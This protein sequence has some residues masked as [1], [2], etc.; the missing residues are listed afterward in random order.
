G[1]GLQRGW[2]PQGGPC[3]DGEV[4]GAAVQ[5]T[6]SLVKM[7]SGEWV[8]VHSVIGGGR[9]RPRIRVA[10]SPE[11]EPEEGGLTGAPWSKHALD[12]TPNWECI[13]LGAVGG[14]FRAGARMAKVHGVVS[15]GAGVRKLVVAVGEGARQVAIQS[16]LKDFSPARVEGWEAN[17][18]GSGERRRRR[19][20]GPVGEEGKAGKKKQQRRA[21]KRAVA[22]ADSDETEL[23]SDDES[24]ELRG[25][26]AG[27][28]KAKRRRVELESEEWEEGSS[29]GETA[30]KRVSRRGSCGEDDRGGGDGRRSPTGR[31]GSR[32][33]EHA[34]EGEEMDRLIPK[35]VRL[36]E[37]LR[38][39]F[40]KQRLREA[41]HYEWPVDLDDEEE[42]WAMKL[43]A[44]YA[45][46]RLQKV[47][48]GEVWPR[49]KVRSMAELRELREAVDDALVHK[50]CGGRVAEPRG[51]RLAEV[52][53]LDKEGAG[54]SSSGSGAKPL[55][56]EY[57]QGAFSSDVAARIHARAALV[58]FQPGEDVGGGLRAAPASLRDDL[59]RA[60]GSNGRIDAA[61]EVGR[62]R[63]IMPLVVKHMRAALLDEVQIALMA[64]PSED[65]S[66]T[67]YM[68]PSIA[69]KLAS[70]SVAGQFDV[71][72]EYGKEARFV[73]GPS[74][75]AADTREGL[76]E[77]WRVLR[78]ALAAVAEPLYGVKSSDG[79]IA[80]VEA[81]VSAT[82]GSLKMDVRAVYHHMLRRVFEQWG[83]ECRRFRQSDGDR[84][85]FQW[86]VETHSNFFHTKA[87]VAAFRQ[88]L[89]L[90]GDENDPGRRQEGRAGSRSLLGKRKE[91]EQRRGGADPPREG[92]G[93][94][95]EKKGE[96]GRSGGP[97]PTQSAWPSKPRMDEEKFE[98]FCEAVRKSCGEF[99]R[100]FLVGRCKKTDCNRPHKVTEAFKQLQKDFA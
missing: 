35:G 3:L 40:R 95:S 77:A 18:R 43:E 88:E 34:G 59:A 19:E 12:E 38:V 39:F 79:G 49:Q 98:K 55:A 5:Q 76:R 23:S 96:G 62:E 31:V 16:F 15:N 86:C 32:G 27:G 71:V 1:D 90:K 14:E 7:G 9:G 22:G 48:G 25:E 73:L 92:E 80:K 93:R 4:E 30:T 100:F 78:V 69:L 54:P 26:A 89:R 24:G 44:S 75:P 83:L 61:G 99:C 81:R 66:G 87:A 64:V 70:A 2:H 11:A 56:A 41:A 20:G 21:A 52:V 6:Q 94:G 28:G 17:H 46:R 57:V 91:D 60:I 53:D 33:E 58:S 72:E 13:I 10:T 47:V 37:A 97:P 74:A 8:V 63:T 82:A 51:G 42:E 85:S 84:P 65:E 45:L 67:Q 68:P 29:A 36:G 50:Q